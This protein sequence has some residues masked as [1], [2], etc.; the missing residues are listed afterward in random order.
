MIPEAPPERAEVGLVPGTRGGEGI[1][2]PGDETAIGHGAGSEQETDTPAQAHS[3]LRKPEPTRCRD[4][5]LP[6]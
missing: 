1:R 5:R 3:R 2:C 4:G 6:G